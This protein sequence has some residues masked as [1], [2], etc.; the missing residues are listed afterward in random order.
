MT[1]E[2]ILSA[3]D[4]SAT[5]R[6]TRRTWAA[7][8]LLAAALAL[9]AG[10]VALIN[11]ALPAIGR[12]LSMGNAIL[13]WLVTAYAVAFA[14]F[15]LFGGRVADVFG[16]RLVFAGGVAVFTVGAVMA[17]AAPDAAVL[18]AGRGLQG[19]GAALSG[20]ASLSL[21]T[22]LFPE[23]PLRN[24]ALAIYTS[25]GASSFAG[26]LVLGGVLTNWLG[27]RAV[28]TFAAIVG[29]LVL[30]PVRHLLPHSE[31]RSQH[32]DLPG[33]IMVTAAL[34]LAVYG[35]SRAA[36]FGWTDSAALG[37]LSGAGLL[38]IAFAMWERRSPD[39]L[40]PFNIIGVPSVR[41]AAIAAVAFF[42]PLL[43]VLFFAPLYMERMLGYS[44]IESG[45][46][47]VPM[48]LTVI[49]FA[50][51]AGRLMSTVGQR[52]LMVIG[53][54]LIAAGVAGFWS[55]TALHGAYWPNILLGVVIMSAGQGTAFAALTVASL[56]GVPQYEHGVAGGFNVT[57]QQIG[58]SVGVAA[59]VTIANVVSGSRPVASDQLSGYHAAYLAGAGIAA[60]G[61]VIVALG[62]VLQDRAADSRRAA[63]VPQA[64]PA[65][66]SMPGQEQAP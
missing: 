11:P 21:V 49:V 33:T 18:I 36:N 59:L 60:V 9:D 66:A 8:I 50:N 52:P 28:F 43:G 61:A 25:V 57:A 34:V 53:L 15:L 16:R 17:A 51:L 13:Q 20:P 3:R 7:L 38:F 41:A 31:R 48:G 55:R 42:T 30:L 40:L 4:Q 63:A 37:S 14:G 26:G 46:A 35:F 27:W 6:V 44:P 56:T 65:A 45:L 58:G 32:L 1:S 19:L 47:I 23:G 24:R 10:G 12:E 64:A 62:G 5:P 54:L 39:P 29:G 2:N 22:Q